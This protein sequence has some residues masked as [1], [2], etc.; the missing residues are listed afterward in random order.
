MNLQLV[1]PAEGLLR[2][3]AG[4]SVTLN[5][6]VRAHPVKKVLAAVPGGEDYVW[7]AIVDRAQDLVGNKAGHA[8][9]QSGAVSKPLFKCI[10]EF[11]RDI[12]AIGDSYHCVISLISLQC[13]TE[14]GLTRWTR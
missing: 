14:T 4:L 6:L 12:D 9:H 13:G 7:I 3:G 5:E 11:G 1:R 2:H 8:V 10:G